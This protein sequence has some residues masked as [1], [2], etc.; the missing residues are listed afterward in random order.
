MEQPNAQVLYFQQIKNLL[1][2]HLSVVDEIAKVLAISTDSA[3]RRI[4]GEKPITFEEIKL[5]SARYKISI[6]QFLHIM[7][8]GFIFSGKLE[9]P[10][11][12]FF[13]QYLNNMLQQFE[14]IN[15]FDHGHIYFLPKDIPLFMYFQFP[16]LATFT[17]FYYM[18]SLL[19]LDEMKDSKFSVKQV[20]PD[21][22]KLGKKIQASFNQIDSTE[23]WGWEIIDSILRHIS[24][25]KDTQVF[26]SK[27]DILYLY[28]QLEELM[29]HIEKQ[30][31]L[32]LKFTFGELPEKR[33]GTFKLF[34]NDLITG[35]NSVL[36]EI[37][38]KKVTYINHNLINFMYTRNEA[39]NNYTAS[40]FENAIRKSTQ[41]S[42]VGGKDRSRFFNG[43]CNKIQAQKE[44]IH[45]Y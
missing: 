29:R 19:N 1:P 28:D 42:L 7:D 43:L 17:L 39:F 45:R 40:T 2:P 21:H 6:D 24:F 15:T 22:V 14:Y 38:N 8:H 25:Y 20:K 23:I 18:K 33:T 32:G 13:E 36:V 41:I 3:Y 11:T 27:E 26:D 5:L 30:A 16:E 31:A 35:D 4:R 10:S 44:A 12:D 37:G 9:Y 34:F